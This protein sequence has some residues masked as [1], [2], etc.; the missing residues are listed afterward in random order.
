MASVPKPAICGPHSR[1][2]GLTPRGRGLEQ[3][4]ASARGPTG[5]IDGRI[6]HSGSK[7]QYIREIPEIVF[8]RILVFMWS[9]GAL[10]V[11]SQGF[12]VSLGLYL[13]LKGSDIWA[14]DS[15]LLYSGAA[16]CL[17]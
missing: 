9:F 15:E 16:M 17:E 8:G 10:N 7:A 13:R 11:I 6:S 3:P 14:P 4:M 12:S 2:Y 5:H 1:F